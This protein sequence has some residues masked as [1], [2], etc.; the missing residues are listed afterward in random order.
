MCDH[1]QAFSK[2]FAT[3]GKKLHYLPPKFGPYIN[4]TSQGEREKKME[5]NKMLKSTRLPVETNLDSVDGSHDAKHLLKG[6]RE[7][8][9]VQKIGILAQTL[10]QGSI[11]VESNQHS[12][13]L[14]HGAPSPSPSLARDCTSQKF[15]VRALAISLSLF[16]LSFQNSPSF[17]P[18]P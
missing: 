7:R 15:P 8:P 6:V 4:D 5:T 17:S 11:H 3:D 18:F 14:R 12:P 9:L 16:A 2:T 13:S 10:H 1:I